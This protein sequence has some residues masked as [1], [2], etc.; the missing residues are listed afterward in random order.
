LATR[1]KTF[2][3]K[4]LEFKEKL[5]YTIGGINSSKLQRYCHLSRAKLY[6]PQNKLT[7]FIECRLDI[8]L[9]KSNLVFDPKL[10]KFLIQAGAVIVNKQIV[11]KPYYRLKPGDIVSVAMPLHFYRF[12]RRRYR[13]RIRRRLLFVPSPSY[14]EVNYKTLQFT[15]LRRPLP[16]EVFYPYSYSVGYFFRLYNK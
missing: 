2:F 8:S 7:N 1:R 16:R 10:N 4:A 5:T 13:E 9:F 15:L 11:D 3:G 14:M 6:S 12:L